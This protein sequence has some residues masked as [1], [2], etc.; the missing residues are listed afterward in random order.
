[1]PGDKPF[2]VD[3]DRFNRQCRPE[4]IIEPNV[5]ND[6]CVTQGIHVPTA[7]LGMD[8]HRLFDAEEP[9]VHRPL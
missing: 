6:Q 4:F 1:M 3:L 5:F 7:D 9:P 8:A 2:I